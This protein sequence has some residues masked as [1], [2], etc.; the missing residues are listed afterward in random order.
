M[1]TNSMRE[2]DVMQAELKPRKRGSARWILVL[3]AL[4]IAVIFAA[5]NA[6]V[7]ILKVFAWRFEASLA[8][9]IVLCFAVGVLVS[10]IALLPRVY[11]GRSHERRLN[12]K[13]ADLETRSGA[14][15][16]PTGSDKR[17]PNARS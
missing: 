13:I 17:E 15:S 14:V 7:V 6:D 10:L 16:R 4:V 5:Q 1:H 11:K 2:G 9:I 3:V 12:A 8:V